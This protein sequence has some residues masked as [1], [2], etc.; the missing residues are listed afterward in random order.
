MSVRPLLAL[1]GAALVALVPAAAAA[2]PPVPA[3]AEPPVFSDASVHD[4][5]LVV[6]DGEFWVF[7]SH[8]AAARSD[9][10]MNWE[11]VADGANA[12]NPLFEDV[13]AELA[14]TFEWAQTDTL[15]AADVIQLEDGRFYMYYNA[16]KGDSPR[17]AMGVAVAD[18]VDGPYED[19]GIILRS[20]MWD[21]PSEDGTIY[22]ARVHPNVVDPDTF[23]D[24]E[25]NLWMVYGSYSGGIFILEMDRATGL[26]VPGQGYG[27]HLMGGNHSRIEGPTIMYNPETEYY[28]LFSSFGGLG[29]DGGYNMRVAR[30]ANPDGPYVDAEGNPMSEVRS[31]PSLPLFDDASIE[32]FGVKLMGSHLFGHEVGDPG[33][34]PG[35]GYVSPGHNTT[36][37]DPQTGEQ[38]LIFHTRFP[39]QGEFHQIRTHQ[40]FMNE[41]GWPVVAPY[42][43]A[44]GTH[45]IARRPDVVG[46][47]AFI[48][49]GK[50]I[51]ADLHEASTIEL[52]RNGEITGAVEGRWHLLQGRDQAR[53]TIDGEEYTGVFARQWEPQSASWVL[54]FT[55]QSDGGVSLW[56]SRL[57]PLTDQQALDA[58]LAD[59]DL[60]DTSAVIAD[61][62]LPTEGTRGVGIEWASSDPA[63]VS[64]TGEVVRPEPGAGDAHV[65][66]TATLT[67]GE[68]TATATFAVVVSEKLVGGL[69]ARYDFDG[70][71]AEAQGR[72][73]DGE[74]TGTRID[75]TGGAV[76]YTEGVSG[77]ALQLDGTA[78]VRLPDGL[79]VGPTYSVS[80]WLR[81]D[82]LTPYTTTFFGARDPNNWVSLLPQGHDGVGGDTMVWSGNA[83]YDASAGQQIP[84]GE[85]THLALTVDDGALTVY[86]DGVEAFAGT[87]FPDVFTTTSGAF[88]L[89]VNWWDTPFAGAVDE[90]ELHTTALTAAEV[91]ALAG[92]GAG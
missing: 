33:E 21:E 41:R 32:P 54:T 20:G 27:E 25:G 73:A 39:G 65:T 45:D 15:W 61:L 7:G 64:A 72:V 30:S 50:E 43:Y 59:L 49:H 11:L 37:Y 66:L 91:A 24:A 31:D 2:R 78:G 51:S 28:Y 90:L 23:F 60:G 4:P 85:W 80:L 83:W 79:I 1:I 92:S 86:V 75:T 40:M 68:L 6:A 18:S 14:E 34:E 89:G 17:S 12:N 56:G 58:V 69:V 84:T 48:D 62:D 47:Y 3:P 5:S 74:P 19:L 8:L 53:L 55:V 87:G 44:P 29:A 52:H 82:A 42:R 46:E 71:L 22:D 70:D 63:V 81:P 38:F 77:Q 76:G 67:Q 13:R 10:L 9:D 16:C 88:A 35:V 26:P 36:Y 57:A